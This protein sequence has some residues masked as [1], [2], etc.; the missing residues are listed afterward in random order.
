VSEASDVAP[1]EAISPSLFERLRCPARVAFE[2]SR[3]GG[4]RGLSPHALVGL[5]FHKGLELALRES[6]SADE[7]WARAGDALTQDGHDVGPLKHTARLTRRFRRAVSQICALLEANPPIGPIA[8]ESEIR[9]EDGILFGVPDLAW[10]TDDGAFIVDYKTSL[11]LREDQLVESYRR[12]LTFYCAL[13]SA[14]LRCGVD[15]AV[16]LSTKEGGVE[17]PIRLEELDKI[18]DAARDARAAFNDRLPGPQP[19]CPDDDSCARCPFQATCDAFWQAAESGLLESAGACRVRGVLI[20]APEASSHGGAGISVK[21]VGEG[22]SSTSIVA[23]IPIGLLASARDGVEIR[24]TQLRELSSSGRP[25]L[26]WQEDRSQ[27]KLAA[28]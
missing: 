22:E 12:Q 4:R 7:A 6:L 13:I 1:L 19:A 20:G 26:L 27:L 21:S 10:Q 28:S 8:I 2:R 11:V 16:L 17:V 18:I 3:R 23:G 9:S 15:R 5:L 25:L 14:K 24:M